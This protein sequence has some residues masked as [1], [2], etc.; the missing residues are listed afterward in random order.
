MRTRIDLAI[1]CLIAGMVCLFSGPLR[2]Q[3]FR[4]DL[5][6]PDPT[7]PDRDP[8]TWGIAPGDAM[9]LTQIDPFLLS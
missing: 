9:P 3:G 1:I 6:N 7:N 2:A 5:A 8:V 4:D